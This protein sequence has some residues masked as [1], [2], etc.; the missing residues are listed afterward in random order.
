MTPADTQFDG[1]GSTPSS[2]EN[3]NPFSCGG[4]EGGG[5][6][7]QGGGSQGEGVRER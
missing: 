5:G 2:S 3:P 4:G 7:S 6:W 1:L